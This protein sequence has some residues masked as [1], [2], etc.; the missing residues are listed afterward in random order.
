[1]CFSKST[2]PPTSS[3]EK[4]YLSVDE[5][6]PTMDI[7]Q[8]REEVLPILKDISKSPGVHSRNQMESAGFKYTG[9]NDTARCEHCKLTVS[10]WDRNMEP[11]S[12]H[13]EKSPACPFFDKISYKRLK[14][15]HT[16]NDSSGNII[17]EAE[18]IK[19]NRRR[20]F[21]HWPRK[22]LELTS[23]MIQ[24]GFFSCNVNDRVICLYC[25]IICE[26]WK[27]NKD[28]PLKVHKT[29]SPKCPY[30]VGMPASTSQYAFNDEE[31]AYKTAINSNYVAMSKRYASFGN[32]SNQ[33][34]PKIDDLVKAGFFFAGEDTVVTC[35][36]CDGSFRNLNANDNPMIEHARRFPHCDYAK[37][38]CGTELYRRIQE[39]KSHSQGL[40]HN[41]L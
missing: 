32:W 12:I 30:I 15:D 6:V 7:G 14:L 28:D 39:A 9:P 24:A 38:L 33:N 25:N 20:T 41:D 11:L 19:E 35:F 8:F 17:I 2:K 27:Q 3:R 5:H 31:H 34:M 23:Q 1:M 40:F 26:Q 22:S 21:S 13:K 16:A 37:Q 10:R 4:R 36:Y 29:I 18:N